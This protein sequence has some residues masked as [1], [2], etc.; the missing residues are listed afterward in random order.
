M[1]Q[2]VY[3]QEGGGRMN[4]NTRERMRV[5]AWVVGYKKRFTRREKI[6]CVHDRKS[7]RDWCRKNGIDEALFKI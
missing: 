7:I 2:R 6:Q 3:V 4:M 5:R 1:V